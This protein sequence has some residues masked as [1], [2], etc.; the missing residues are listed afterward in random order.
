MLEILKRQIIL[1]N[2]LKKQD[3]NSYR[4]KFSYFYFSCRGSSYSYS[5]ISLENSSMA[6][7]KLTK[8]D[9]CLPEAKNRISVEPVFA[10]FLPNK[11][12]DRPAR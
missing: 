10:L 5:R 12:F 3:T 4:E 2:N 11:L 6:A 1:L 7:K 9:K 8:K